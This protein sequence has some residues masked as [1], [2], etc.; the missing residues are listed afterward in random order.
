MNIVRMFII[1]W[2]V[3]S[4]EPANYEFSYEVNSPEYNVQFGHHET[5]HGDEANGLYHVLLPDGRTQI[6]EYQADQDGYKPKVTYQEASSG[7]GGSGNGANGFGGGAGGAGY[8]GGAGGAG[9]GGGAGY[10]GGAGGAGYGGGAG[11]AGGAGYSGGAGYGSGGPG[12]GF[13]SKSGNGYDSAGGTGFGGA[14]GSGGYSA[15]KLIFSLV[16]WRVTG[17][18]KG[19]NKTVIN[20]FCYRSFWQWQWK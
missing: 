11:G 17:R 3:V 9:F 20:Q 18:S 15:G 12:N 13:A 4:Q 5:R 14:G 1:K 2:F 8:G 16:N 6:V 19:S 7:L 10:G